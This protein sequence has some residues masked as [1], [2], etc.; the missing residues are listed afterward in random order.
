[1]PLIS[2]YWAIFLTTGSNISIS[3]PRGQFDS[4]GSLPSSKIRGFTSKFLSEIMTY[5]CLTIFLPNSAFPS[6]AHL[7]LI[8]STE[9][10]IT[11]AIVVDLVRGHREYKEFKKK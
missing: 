1:M 4:W 6:V 8:T 5:G 11:Q 3:Y 2:F 10:K 7:T 9:K